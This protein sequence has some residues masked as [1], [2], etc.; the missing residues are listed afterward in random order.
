M[1][2]SEVPSEFVF[3]FFFQA[4]D[5]IRDIGVTGVQTCALPI[6]TGAGLERIAAMVQGKENNFETDLLFPLVEEAGRLTNSKYHESPETDFS[7]KVITDHSRAVTF[8]IHDGV[9]PSNEGRGYVLRR[10]LRRA[11]R[12]GRLLGQT[13]LFLY[14]MVEKVVDQFA[15]AYPDLTANMENIQKI[16]KIEEEKFSNTLDQGIQLVNEQIALALQAGKAKLDGEITFKMYDTYGFPYELTEEICN[17]KGIAVSQEE[18]LE[19]M[20]EQKEKAR[21]ARAVIMEKGQDSFIEEKI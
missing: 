19:K 13:N 7:L 8:L 16:V 20:E 17:E 14:K 11:V 6:Y 10:I 21:S 15:I 3:F 4:E 12:H 5:G 2:Q 9:I 1:S 18:F